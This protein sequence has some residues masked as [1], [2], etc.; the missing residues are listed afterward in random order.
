MLFFIKIGPVKDS[1]D[2]Q[3]KVTKCHVLRGK[4]RGK[5]RNPKRQWRA[6][7]LGSNPNIFRQKNRPGEGL[8]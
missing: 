1:V 3:Q 7:P 5:K 8:R 6:N 4:K 2:E